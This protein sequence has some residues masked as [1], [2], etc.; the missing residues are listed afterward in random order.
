MNAKAYITPAAIVIQPP[1][2]VTVTMS[3]AQAETLRC[4]LGRIGG[5]CPP[6]YGMTD[7]GMALDDAGVKAA[8]HEIAPNNRA[9]YFVLTKE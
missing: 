3:L 2:T 4:I 6:R 9:I 1:S 8:L 5:D 7:L